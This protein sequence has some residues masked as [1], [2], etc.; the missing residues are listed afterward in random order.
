[1]YF[2]TQQCKTSQ[3][4]LRGCA[5]KYKKCPRCGLNYILLTEETCKVCLDELSGTKSIFDQEADDLI[6]PYC[7]RNKMGIDEIMC[8]RCAMKRRQ[9]KDNDQTN[10]VKCDIIVV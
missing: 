8:S 5:L 1:M 6:C 7:Q 3:V 2:V 10:N 4:K 9:N